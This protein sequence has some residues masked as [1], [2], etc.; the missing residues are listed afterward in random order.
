MLPRQL[1]DIAYV[2]RVPNLSLLRMLPGIRG[3][4]K[5]AEAKKKH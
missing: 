4:G 2:Y 5:S 1:E 3:H